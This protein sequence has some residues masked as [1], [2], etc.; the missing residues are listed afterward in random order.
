VQR[1]AGASY[2][3]QDDGRLHFGLGPAKTI[4]KVRVTWPAGHTQE[5][6]NLPADR[7]ITLEEK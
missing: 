1:V 6:T 3:G 7:V 4:E 5:W 2:L